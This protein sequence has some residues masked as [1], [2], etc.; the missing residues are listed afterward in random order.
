MHVGKVEHCLW[1]V[2]LLCGHSVVGSCDF[3]VNLSALTIVMIVTN[4]NTGNCVTWRKISGNKPGDSIRQYILSKL[5]VI[6]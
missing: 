1:V 4:L 2:L 5:N 3:V 6:S